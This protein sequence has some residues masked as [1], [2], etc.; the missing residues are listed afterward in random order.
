[1]NRDI[2]ESSENVIAE[3]SKRASEGS[4]AATDDGPAALE[5]EEISTEAVD[6][7]DEDEHADDISDAVAEPEALEIAVEDA[8]AED[9]VAEAEEADEADDALPSASPLRRST[10]LASSTSPTATRSSRAWRT[11]HAAQWGSSSRAST[12]R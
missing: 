6:G 12:V 3:W 10:R 7:T 5:L 1:M 2:D 9:A 11:A 4:V 8:P